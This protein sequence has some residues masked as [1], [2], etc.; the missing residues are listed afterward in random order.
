[1]PSSRLPARA[2]PTSRLQLNLLDTEDDALSSTTDSSSP[3]SP[4]TASIAPS[5]TTSH[6]S[7]A[8]H[9]P[10]PLPPNPA[11]LALRTRLHSKLSH[12]LH[13]LTAS[14]QAELSKL[15]MYEI[16]LL[17][18]EPAILDE[19]QRLQVVRGVCENVRDRYKVVVEEAEKRLAEYEQ[20]GE[21]PEVDEIVC[22]STVVYN[23]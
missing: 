6:H 10:P 21:G 14:A 15:D 5:H 4:S 3:L 8:S 23:Q 13:S 9:V 12:H 11:L 7:H 17:K 1:M 20:R 16:D 2:P 22:S 18:G 19:M